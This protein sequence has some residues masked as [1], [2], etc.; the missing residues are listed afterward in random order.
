MAS[1]VTEYTPQ[2]V[3]KGTLTDTSATEH[4]RTEVWRLL[5][6][7]YPAS[8]GVERR[9]EQRYPY[10]NLVRLTPVDAAGLPCGPVL[11]VAGKHLSE[12]GMGFFHPTPL[13]ARRVI[14]VL[15]GAADRRLEVIV[16][17]N[18]CRFTRHGWYESGG[19]F[20]SVVRST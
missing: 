13:P 18:W 12:S 2:A 3:P 1:L 17:L 7:L 20:L 4:V 10:P 15:E 19:K 14:A 11:M 9:R 16:D 5:S 8:G 6:G